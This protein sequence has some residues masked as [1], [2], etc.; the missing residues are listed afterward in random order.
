M[1]RNNN[2]STRRLAFESLE[3]RQMLDAT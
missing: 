1:T 3:Q 2:G